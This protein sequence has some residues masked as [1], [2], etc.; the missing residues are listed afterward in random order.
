VPVKA[1]EIKHVKFS[2]LR[3]TELENFE[4][5]RIFSSIFKLPMMTEEDK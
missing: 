3:A 4:C 2:H 5:M 1:N